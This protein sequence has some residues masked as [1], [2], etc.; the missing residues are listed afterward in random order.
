MIECCMPAKRTWTIE[1]LKI[2]ITQST[3]IRQTLKR[4]GLRGTGGNYAQ[5]HQY[6]SELQLNIDHFRGMAWNKGLHPGGMARR[7]LTEILVNNSNFQSYKLKLRLIAANLKLPLELDHINGNRYDNRIE[8]LRI[9]CPNCHSL[10]ST[11]R[12]RKKHA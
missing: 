7:T 6:I 11:Y 8:N 12:R 5:M 4:L 3:S 10:T 9:L 2:A 1:Q